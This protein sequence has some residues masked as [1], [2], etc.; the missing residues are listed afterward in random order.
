MRLAVD[1]M[2]G[3]FG[4]RV[5]VPAAMQALERFP[6]LEI[7]LIG[8]T[9]E[10]QAYALPHLR[11]RYSI[12]HCENALSSGVDVKETLRSKLPNPMSIGLNSLKTGDVAGF[13]SAG[14]TAALMTLSLKLVGCFGGIKRPA[15]CAQLPR[16]DGSFFLL[17]CGANLSASSAQ[18]HQ[19]A[20]MGSA[21]A[22]RTE[23]LRSPRVA[24]LNVGVE[25]LKGS[26]TVKKAAAQLEEDERINFVGFVEGNQLFDPVADIV[27]CDGFVGNVALKT[28]EG[29][30]L[31]VK[32]RLL[33]SMSKGWRRLFAPLTSLL[34]HQVTNWLNPRRHNGASLLGLN[35][36]VVKSHGSAN[37]EAFLSAI[38]CAV[39]EVQTQLPS[40]IESLL[41]LQRNE[42]DTANSE[43]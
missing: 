39:R 4:P 11:S 18:L 22:K 6:F 20:L 32:D 41:A 33:Q 31:H 10:V 8:R 34:V 12:L 40:Q 36:V 21:L 37:Q 24:L 3:D 17:D 15:I 43:K 14:N 5:A 26:S 29:L 9:D 16:Q 27:V 38:D 28:T 35:E 42:V 1:V 30:A 13:V 2:S 19:F 7:V 23:N 25:Q